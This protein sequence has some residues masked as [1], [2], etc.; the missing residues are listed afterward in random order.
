M[1]NVLAEVITI[2]D[3]ILY[4]QTL[5]TNSHFISEKLGEV[6]VK[7]WRKTTIADKEEDILA[8]FKEAEDKV[9]IVIITGG[10]GPT[11]DD[12]TKPCLAKYFDCPIEIHE[13]ALEELTTYFEQR[14]RELTELNRNQ[15]ALPTAC[16]MISNPVGTAPGMWFHHKGKVFVSLPGV[17][18]EMKYLIENEVIGRVLKTFPLPV[19]YHKMIKTCGIGESFLADIIKD[20][21]DSLPGHFKLAYLPTLGEVKLRLTATGKE[22]IVLEKEAR[23]L[24]EELKNLASKY[25]YGFDDDSLESK[26]GELLT[27]RGLTVSTAESCTGGHLA[28]TL[29]SVPGSSRYYRGS[30][31]AYHN[32]I[33][34]KMLDVSGAVLQEHGAVSEETITLMAQNVREKLGTDIGLATSGVAGPDGGTEEKPVGL[35]WIAYSDKNGTEVKKVRFLKDRM[36]NIQYSSKSILTLL[37]RKLMGIS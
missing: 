36:F 25:I 28:H 7:I 19:I 22:R 32:D 18:H 21:E 34:T 3:E 11:N 31:I 23:L 24:V 15:A 27:K 12:L 5:D 14:G 16:E 2:G 26:V 35:V 29:T 20:W 30:V 6:G 13:K 37:Y 9:D 1:K 10:L 8:A 33:K 17:P 4:G